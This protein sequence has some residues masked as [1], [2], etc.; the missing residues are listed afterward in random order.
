MIPAVAVMAKVPGAVAAKSRLQPPLTPAQAT[1]L[2]RCFLADRL[3]GLLS[4]AGVRHVV[5]FTPPEAGA[6]MAGFAPPGFGLV[7]Q[8][9]G[10]LGERLSG[11]LTDLLS[12]GHDGAIAIDSDS[13]TLPMAYVADAARVLEREAADV[14]LGPCE[15][16][17]YYLI[18]LR[19]PAPAL[20]QDIPW[21]TDQVLRL[22]R[23]KAEDLHLRVH[24]LP[25][26]FD[27][28]TEADLRRLHH[29]LTGNG[30]GPR[31]T[32]AFVRALY[33]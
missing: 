33:G 10:D 8:R 13:P 31:R 6:L 7:A 16:G 25:P 22:T 24:L 12:A 32:R 19:A 18:G 9:G 28:D 27:V 29:E 4:V 20:F 21:S 26:W 14:V 3:D 17:G 23:E 15:D 11:L 1:E 2:Y 5:A 30:D